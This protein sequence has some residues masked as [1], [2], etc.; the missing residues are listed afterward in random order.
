M[1]FAIESRPV[2]EWRIKTLDVSDYPNMTAYWVF[3][4]A[5][6]NIAKITGVPEAERNTY[7]FIVPESFFTKERIGPLEHQILLEDSV[8]YPILPTIP[9]QDKLLKVGVTPTEADL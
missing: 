3:R 2:I 8:G 7:H 4:F 6:G 5:N 9:I 1:T